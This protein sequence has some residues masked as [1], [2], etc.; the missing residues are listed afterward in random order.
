M[1]ASDRLITCRSKRQTD[2][3]SDFGLFSHVFT[4]FHHLDFSSTP[5]VVDSDD[6]GDE[7]KTEED[8][9][10]A[11]AKEIFESD[12]EEDIDQDELQDLEKEAEEEGLVPTETRRREGGGGE[13]G[14][15][16]KCPCD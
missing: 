9:R 12:G 4:L 6:S 3:L 13:D 2:Y 11:V 1:R 14:G 10:E 5:K 16:K 15:G 7:K 8:D